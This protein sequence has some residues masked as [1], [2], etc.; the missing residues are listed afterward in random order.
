MVTSA[1]TVTQP[2]IGGLVAGL[3][4]W[5]STV[6]VSTALFGLNA[7]VNSAAHSTLACGDQVADEI[8]HLRLP[9]GAWRRRDEC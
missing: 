6:F 8:R 5:V 2:L 7:P 4:V 1:S 3:V 9:G